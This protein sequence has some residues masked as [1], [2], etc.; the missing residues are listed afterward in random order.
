[1]SAAGESGLRRQCG[2][3][4]VFFASFPPPF[5]FTVPPGQPPRQLSGVIVLHV[6]VRPGRR[7]RIDMSQT[8]SVLGGR[9]GPPRHRNEWA[10]ADLA[11][12]SRRVR[13]GQR[14]VALNEMLVETT[15]NVWPVALAL[16]LGRRGRRTWQC[17][18]S[19]EGDMRALNEGAGVD[20]NRS[21]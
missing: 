19:A 1:M 7:P 17:P 10:K 15:P 12:S 9:A 6:Q 2:G 3:S 13:Q 14:I 5:D 20:P 18:H 4:V 21:F 11:S 8:L 16:L